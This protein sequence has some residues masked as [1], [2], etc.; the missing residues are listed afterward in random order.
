MGFVCPVVLSD[1]KLQIDRPL[2]RGWKAEEVGETTSLR[3]MQRHESHIF[4]REVYQKSD[5]FVVPFDGQGEND[6]T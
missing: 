4:R 1:G 6:F 3:P 2:E 5:K